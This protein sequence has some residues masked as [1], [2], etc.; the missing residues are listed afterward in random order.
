MGEIVNRVKFDGPLPTDM[1]DMPG[2]GTFIPWPDD[3]VRNFAQ[4]GRSSTKHNSSV[5]DST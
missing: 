3:L 5:R 4:G 2:P 1:L